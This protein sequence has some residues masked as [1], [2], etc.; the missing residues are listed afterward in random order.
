LL[1]VILF[2]LLVCCLFFLFCLFV[3][4]SCQYGQSQNEDPNLQQNK[5]G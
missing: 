4:G 1:L 5:T 2:L 3:F